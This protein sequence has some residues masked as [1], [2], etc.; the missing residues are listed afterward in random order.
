MNLKFRQPNKTTAIVIIDDTEWGPLPWKRLHSYFTEITPAGCE[1]DSSD[2]LIDEIRHT[3][4]NRLQH[5]LAIR[6]RTHRECVTFLKRLPLHPALAREIIAKAE[7][8]N[9][10]N[11]RRYAEMI[12]RASHGIG[13]NM[14]RYK[15]RQARIPTE[16]IDEVLK[17]ELPPDRESEERRARIEK[18]WRKYARDDSRTRFRKVVA[19]LYRLG[20]SWDEVQSDLQ[21]ITNGEEEE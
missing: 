19:A 2:E 17:E 20:Y 18:L 15:L 13:P 12:V 9:F 7:D 1:I 14:I 6:E 11:D 3:A 21:S 16:M 10:L 5:Y 4:W 8:Y